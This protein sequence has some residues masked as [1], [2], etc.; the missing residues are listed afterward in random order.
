MMHLLYIDPGTGSMLFSIF[1]GLA[2]ALYFFA[3][4]LLIKLKVVFSGGKSAALAKQSGRP[5]FVIYN[6]GAQYWNVFKPVLDAFER[7]GMPVLYLTSAEKDIF[8]SLS[9]AYRHITGEYIG[10]G[11]RAFARLNVLEADVCLMTTPALEVY[12][13]K[14][15]KGV[16]HYAHILH[17]TG[18]AT[19]YRLFGLDWFDS[20]LLSGEYQKKD[21]QELERIRGT[22]QKE[23][24]VVGSTYLDVFAEK[25]KALPPPEENRPFTVLVSPSWGKGSLLQAF[26]ERLLDPL[27][28]TGWRI[29]VRP[30]PQ[31]RKSEPAMLARLEERYK[32]YKNYKNTGPLEWDYSPENLTTLSRA[33]VMISDFSGIIFDYIFLFD[34]PVVYTNA[35]FNMEMYDASDLD[36]NPWRFEAVKTFGKELK[37]ADLAGI[38]ALIEAAVKDEQSALAQKT[39]KETA[40][41]YIGESGERAVD[42]L[43]NKQK[44]LAQ[45]GG[46]S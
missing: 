41:Q 17:D 29:I 4:T 15:S 14:R 38:A 32:N 5:G 9:D 24:A 20:L 21:V 13:L 31:S 23:L 27:A 2:A 10:G 28:E 16:L 44:I 19:C 8:F 25:V 42:F 37:E 36:H 33:D 12:Q 6:E 43:V 22:R 30:H 18:D 3:R 40:W 45:T 35:F 46:I 11:N 26:G 34:K 7:R 39:A 1:M